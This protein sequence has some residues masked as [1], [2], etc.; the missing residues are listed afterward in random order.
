MVS[1]RTSIAF[2][3]SVTDVKSYHILV[4]STGCAVA[5]PKKIKLN[6]HNIAQI[7]HAAFKAFKESENENNPFNTLKGYYSKYYSNMHTMEL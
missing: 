3:E 1:Q 5:P 2:Y 6:E 4:L 7:Q